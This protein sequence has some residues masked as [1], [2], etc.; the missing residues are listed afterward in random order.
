MLLPVRFVKTCTSLILV[1]LGY[2]CSSAQ[3]PEASASINNSWQT[4]NAA[5]DTA[6][7]FVHGILSDA[8]AC[9]TAPPKAGKSAYW[10]ELVA[11]DSAFSTIT[12]DDNGLPRKQHVSVFRAGYFTA[13]DAGKYGVQDCAVELF[14]GLDNPVK[15]DA[16]LGKSNILFIC[17]STG[18][19]VV[20]QMLLNERDIFRPKKIGLLLVASPALGSAW[21]KQL[22]PLARKL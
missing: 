1:F 20:R 2:G 9:W 16:A 14:R 12:L 17:H 8:K 4:N 10:P 11:K 15:S 6:I 21:G 7:V 19:L 3:Q 13:W 22:S 5:S 18:G